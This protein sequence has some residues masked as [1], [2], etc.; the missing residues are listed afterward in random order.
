MPWSPP[1]PTARAPTSDTP[2][3]QVGSVGPSRHSGFPDTGIWNRTGSLN[4]GRHSH[5]ATV[6]PDG[7]VLVAGGTSGFAGSALDS[8]EIFDP[9]DRANQ[10]P[11]N[12]PPTGTITSPTVGA[13]YRAGQTI[14][15]SGTGMDAE[16]GS[17]PASAWTWRVDFHHDDGTLHTH[18]FIAAKSGAKGGSFVI[19][20]SGE[21]SPKVF[22]RIVLT[23][24][25]SSGLTH[26]SF[27]D[28]LPRTSTITLETDPPGLSLTLDGQPYTG[29]V[30]GVAGM[31]RSIGAPTPQVVGKVKH[32][33]RRWTDGGR[34]T[35]NITTPAANATYTAKFGRSQIWLRTR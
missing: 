25:D 12:T 18:P 33:F 10:P 23:V 29:P 3:K 8:A 17:L 34:A 35:H 2:L 5:T 13:R 20:T 4:T 9:E 32:A 30:V 16:D 27:R 14:S 28:V 24:T 31:I 7:R 26:V 11:V 19:P 15:Y 22:Y 6:L 1:R 21:T